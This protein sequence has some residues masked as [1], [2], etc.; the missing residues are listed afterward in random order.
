MECGLAGLVAELPRPIE[1]G[2]TA[3]ISIVVRDPTGAALPAGGNDLTWGADACASGNYIAGVTFELGAL[4][5]EKSNG[6]CLKRNEPLTRI[7]LTQYTDLLGNSL[8]ASVSL[9][10]LC[11]VDPVP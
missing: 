8:F 9:C 6:T 1:A 11:P 7:G 3:C 2:G 5:F 4:S 10:D